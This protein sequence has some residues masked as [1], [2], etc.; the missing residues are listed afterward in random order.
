MSI[1]I[2]ITK[3]LALVAFI[4]SISSCASITDMSSKNKT[5]L[6]AAAGAVAGV[7]I[8]QSVGTTPETRKSLSYMG[9]GIGASTG[10][11]LGLNVFDFQD[12]ST[13]T[14]Q[15][16]LAL[17]SKAKEF[18]RQMSLEMISKGTTESEKTPPELRAYLKK[19]KWERYKLQRWN[20]DP[21]DENIY[22]KVTEQI[23]LIP[24]EGEE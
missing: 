2:K 11:L 24:K 16:Y 17:E 13:R 14:E 9:G 10:F 19:G 20:Q 21:E 15:E 18:E 3:I 1:E 8:A 6:L 22:Y 12:K 23:K 4:V 7:A 5:Y